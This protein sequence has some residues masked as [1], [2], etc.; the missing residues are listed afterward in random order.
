MPDHL[1]DMQSL[2]EDAT[3]DFTLGDAASALQ[4]LDVVLERDP[5]LFDAWHARAEV[6]YSL[7]RYDD[8]LEAAQRAHELS[9]EDIHINT[10]L[11]RIWL[12]RGSKEQ[13][14]HFGARARMLGWKDQLKQPPPGPTGGA[15]H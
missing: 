3:L 8:A 10:S 1:Q 2:V 15:Q 11:S 4:K 14:E 6:L 5:R 12:E 9:P 13:A 7:Q